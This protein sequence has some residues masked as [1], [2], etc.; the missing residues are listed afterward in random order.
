MT[1]ERI[2]WND[3]ITGETHEELLI[4]VKESSVMLVAEN[5][6]GEALWIP[7]IMILKRIPSLVQPGIGP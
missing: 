3:E 7:K 5:S 4:V 2:T 1:L 6:H